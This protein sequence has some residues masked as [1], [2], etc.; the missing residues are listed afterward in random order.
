[1]HA[2]ARGGGSIQLSV[3]WEGDPPDEGD[4]TFEL[5]SAYAAVLARTLESAGYQPRRLDVVI[6]PGS[7]GAFVL[8]VLGDV[9]GMPEDDFVS[10]ARLTLTSPRLKD[11]DNTALTD[12]ELVAELVSSS[13]LSERQPVLAGAEAIHKPTGL[14]VGRVV[15]GLALGLLLGVVGL[16]R[17][18]FPFLRFPTAQPTPVPVTASA[19][20]PRVA[21]PDIEPTHAVPTPV[22]VMMPTSVPVAPTSVPLAPTS[23]PVAPTSVPLAPTSVPLAPTSVPLATPAP[24]R[25]RVVFAQRFGAPLP[26]W[27][28]DEMGNSWFAESA[29]RL[30]ARQPGRFV[31]VGVPLSGPMADATLTAQFRKVRG[32]AGGGYGFIVR[33]QGLTSERDGQNQAGRY[34]VVE[35]G[36]QGDIGV[37]QREES[38]WI[39]IAPW[40]HSAAVNPGTDPN[41]L[42]LTLRGAELHL[43]VNGQMVAELTYTGLPVA[44]GVGIFVGGDLNE[45]ALEW[46]RI[47]SP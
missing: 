34:L 5:A 16:P 23:V 12:L 6:R 25:P 4:R 20:E 46:L 15:T 18:E 43:E 44:G 37:W 47:E 10:L 32:P 26:G 36:D 41:T 42:A 38:R 9:E 24:P 1:M 11:K 19:P 21:V 35:V 14:P 45:A 30:F 8:H 29:Y 2:V 40:T 27:P 17:L 7:A 33:D 39:D 28:H 3:A 22:P 13:S 31:A